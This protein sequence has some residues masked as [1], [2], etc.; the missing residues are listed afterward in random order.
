MRLE[1]ILPR[2]LEKVVLRAMR[3]AHPYEEVA[4]DIYPVEQAPAAIG[5][6][7]G[8]GY[9]FW[10][11]YASPKPFS[12]VVKGVK[13]VFQANGFQLTDPAPRFVQRIAFAAGKGA[14]FVESAAD[15]GCDLLITGE[16]GYHEA[17][18]V[19]K[20]RGGRKLKSKSNS[21]PMAVLELGHR[22]S[23]CFFSTVMGRWISEAGLKAVPMDVRTQRIHYVGDSVNL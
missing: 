21:V 13:T 5:L 16:A 3:D 22:E 9:G 15:S 10:G 7:K 17:I 19:S 1:T 8:V 14:S 20:Y 12:E 2:G 11:D 23:E 4:Y 18:G 6:A